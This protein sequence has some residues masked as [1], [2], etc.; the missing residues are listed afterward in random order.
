MRFSE[1]YNIPTT[2]EDD[3][4][5]TFMPA[6]TKLFVDPFLIWEQTE[7][8]WASAHDHLIDFFEMV[9]DLVK[10]SKGKRASVSW[11][12][13]QKLLLFPE[14]Y[15]F[16]LG[17]AEGSPMGIGSGAGLQQE[18][19]EGVKVATGLGMNRVAHME[20]L[21]LFQGGMGV[22]RLS[23]MTCNILK[24]YF[25]SYTQEICRRHRVPMREFDVANA[26][27]SKDYCRWVSKRHELPINPSINRPVLLT[28]SKFLR[29]IPVATPDGFWTWAWSNMSEELRGD[30]TFDIARNV[31]RRDKARL[32]RANPDVAALYLKDLEDQPKSAYSIE[33]D[34]DMLVH[35]YEAGGEMAER[36]PLSFV[37]QHA[38]D[39]EKFVEVTVDCFR[40]SIEDQDGWQILWGEKSGREERISQALFRSSVIHYCRA[41]NIDLSGEADA[42]RGPVDFKFSHGWSARALVEI[43]LVRSHKF[44]DGVLAQLPKYQVAEEVNRGFYVAVAYTDDEY[45]TRIREKIEKAASIAS[46]ASGAKITALLIDARKKESASRSRNPDLSEQLHRD[47]SAAQEIA[48]GEGPVSAQEPE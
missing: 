25:I 44:W 45:S 15:E 37:P 33:D 43:K 19:L 26:E 14:P 2:P 36:S 4:F 40:H 35:W 23:D 22:D 8:H 9:F 30:L 13:A 12:Q 3:W 5:D 42:G 41:N 7:G 21:N 16:C 27:W 20:M 28:P 47:V 10:A 31:E 39:F 29:R 32:A 46:E 48:A 34:P 1:Y 11:R 18:M 17:V 6:D 38:G 24:S